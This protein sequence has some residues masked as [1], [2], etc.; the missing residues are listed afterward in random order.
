MLTCVDAMVLMDKSGKIIHC[1][2]QWVELTGYTLSEVEGL[3][4]SVLHGSMTDRAAVMRCAA[5]TKQNK[6]SS[7]SVVNYRRDGSMFVN[8]ICTSPIRGGF[9][10]EGMYV[11]ILQGM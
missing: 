1:N 8:Q 4:C 5:L 2:R 3:D 10:T 6:P 7:M 11:R 9:K